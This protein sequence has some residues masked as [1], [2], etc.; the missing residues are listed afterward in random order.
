LLCAPL[1]MTAAQSWYG[2]CLACSCNCLSI[3]GSS[4]LFLILCH[5]HPPASVFVIQLIYLC[6]RKRHRSCDSE[7]DQQLTPQAK[8]SGSGPSLL[9]SDLDSEVT[10]SCPNARPPPQSSYNCSSSSDSIHSNC[11]SP[12][13]EDSASSL[14]HGLHGDGRSVPYYYINRVLREAHFSSLQSRGHPGST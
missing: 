8:R 4:F 5:P 7:D 10:Q 13:P 2:C 11:T 14:H 1:N 6:Q 9:L 12:K 3:F